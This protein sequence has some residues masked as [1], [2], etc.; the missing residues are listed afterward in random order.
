MAGKQQRAQLFPNT[1]SNRGY[2]NTP[3]SN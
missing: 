2:G 1:G 3:Y